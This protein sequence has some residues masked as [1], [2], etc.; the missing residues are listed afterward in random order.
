MRGRSNRIQIVLES[1]IGTIVFLEPTYMRGRSNRGQ[2]VHKSCIGT[3]VFWSQHTRSS[4][5][6]KLRNAYS[7]AAGRILSFRVGFDLI[8]IRHSICRNLRLDSAGRDWFCFD[9]VLIADGFEGERQRETERDED[10]HIQEIDQ[11]RDKK[12]DKKFAET[13]VGANFFKKSR[14]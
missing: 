6:G 2:I 10:K 13:L 14:P 3:I 1:C 5:Y 7:D 8:W 11:G 12:L 4:K 9:I